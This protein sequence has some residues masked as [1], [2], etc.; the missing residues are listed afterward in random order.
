[1]SDVQWCDLQVRVMVENM[2]PQTMR[3]ATSSGHLPN[4]S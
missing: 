1:M 4:D 3:E 2:E